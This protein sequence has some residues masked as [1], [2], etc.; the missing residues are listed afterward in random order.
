MKNCGI[1]CEYNP[2]HTGHKY[3]LDCV[4]K[5]GADNIV[6]V[7]SGA[8][9][10]SAMPSF[11]D[12][13]LRAKCAIAGGADAVIE[14]PTVFS[15]A[16]AQIFAEGAVK[17]MREIKDLTHIAM[18]S[19]GDTGTVRRLAD[20]KISKRYEFENALKKQLSSGKS[21]NAASVAA[22]AEVYG[23]VYQGSA[24]I[25][26]IMSDPNNI[27]CI[28]YIVAADKLGAKIEPVFIE[29]RGAAHNDGGLDGEFASAT[30]IRTAFE[31]GRRHEAMLYLPC[32]SDEISSWRDIHAANIDMYKCIALFAL[33]CA[34]KERMRELRNC[35]EGLEHLIKSIVNDCD[36]D[37]LTDSIVGK[38]Y[39]KK[40]IDRLILDVVLDIAKAD[41]EKAFVTRLLAC[42]KNFDFSILPDFVKTNNADIKAAARSSSEVADV[43]EIDKKAT[44]LYNTICSVKG[45]YFNYSVVK[46]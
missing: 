17:I 44:A 20:I 40:R 11:C 22:L 26:E 14:L 38:R 36:F 25:S 32:F 4:R 35:S 29:R 10:Q 28:E 39:G 33:K 42:G 2:F 24:D 43:L 37:E 18:G 5:L 9:V 31:N 8:F 19:R 1:V 12:K 6:C 30:A 46:L 16:S 13:A 3:Q 41:T 15:T 34:E 27:L 23:K 21:Y 45:D 7:M